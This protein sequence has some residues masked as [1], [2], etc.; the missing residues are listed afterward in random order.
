MPLFRRDPKEKFVKAVERS[1]RRLGYSESL[2]YDEELFAYRLTGDRLIMLGNIYGHFQSLPQ[3]EGDQYLGVALA[4][5]LQEA[6]APRTLDEARERLFPGIRDRAYLESARMMAELGGH[7]PI[8][9]PHQPLGSTVSALLI[10]DSPASMMTVNEEQ[11]ASWGVEFDEALAVASRNL[12][13]LSGDA[14]WGR[15]VDGTYASM[16]ND[17]YDVS[18]LLLTEVVDEVARDLGIAGDPVAFIPHRN[19]LILTGSDDG[20]ALQAAMELTEQNLDQPSPVSARPIVRKAGRWEDF[21]VPDD[22]PAAPGLERL[23][24]A[25][26]A[27]AHGA[28]VPIIQQVVGDGIF[29]ASCILG[30]KDGV[31]SSTTSW[32]EGAPALI[33][34]TDRILFFR[35]QEETWMVAWEDAEPVIGGMLE[36]TAYYPTR[37]RVSAFPTDEQ[38]AAMPQIEGW[39]DRG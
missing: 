26:L 17:D 37:F 24:K 16:W 6:D 20:G 13:S 27:L 33:P 18:R 21:V 32:S 23:H 1:L 31:V 19:L 5:L 35:S 2:T 12:L 25:D 8:P 4:G 36:P 15:V 11:L 39:Q 34:K 22:H 14:T 28:I 10:L 9:I 7:P 3:Q 38:L 29:V 30:E